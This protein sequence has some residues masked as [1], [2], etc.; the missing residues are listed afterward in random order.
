M[1]LLLDTHVA[2]WA[3]TDRPRIRPHGLAM[4]ADAANTV[5]VSAASIWEIAIKH[6][7]G[8]RRGA[9]PFSAAEADRH[10]R[11]AGFV[12][13]DITPAHAA[14]V[15]KLPLLHGD[16][17]DRMLVAQAL[18]EPMR[19]LTADARVAKYSDLVSLVG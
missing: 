5:F 13:L 14:A 2:I 12:L 17:F 7:L 1:R 3:M 6:A 19:L 15:E 8:K 4:I 9:P 11:D 10:F 16:P 18:T